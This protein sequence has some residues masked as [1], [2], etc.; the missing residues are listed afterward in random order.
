MQLNV[1]EDKTNLDPS[2]G[3]RAMSGAQSLVL[4]YLSAI[5][6]H[7]RIL[8][9]PAGQGYLAQWAHNRGFIVE[10]CDI[11]PNLFRV[12]GINCKKVN[13]NRDPLPYESESFDYVVSVG[14][15]HRLFNPRNAIS[16]AW[17]VL[18]PEG[19]LIIGLK[20]Y[21]S[22]RRR[23][24]FLL[25]GFHGRN[26]VTQNFHQTIADP[27]ANF[28]FPLTAIYLFKMLQDAG[29]LLHETK[30][31]GF[32][33]EG[34]ILFPIVLLIKAHNR[35]RHA[36]YSRKMGMEFSV[37]LPVLMGKSYVLF[38]SRKVYPNDMSKCSCLNP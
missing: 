14:G 32:S 15:L 20:N 5:N 10:C 4:D 9:M 26:I 3:P 33:S 21:T 30:A 36:Y 6:P 2:L 38:V 1:A 12:D 28:R 27:E 17:R 8:D 24:S 29:F 25:T 35:L 18:V 23:L 16:E 13:L 37:P 19:S 34:I 11:D 22:L 7:S 31:D